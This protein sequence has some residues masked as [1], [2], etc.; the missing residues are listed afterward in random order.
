MFV[1]SA[2]IESV[3][4]NQSSLTRRETLMPPTVR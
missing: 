2:T 3:A 4:E 1:A